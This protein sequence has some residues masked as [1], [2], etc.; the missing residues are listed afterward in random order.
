MTTH[1]ENV[2]ITVITTPTHNRPVHPLRAHRGVSTALLC[3]F[4]ATACAAPTDSSADPAPQTEP[5]EESERGH[6]QEAGLEVSEAWMPEPANPEVGALYL[7]VNNDTDEDDALVG[8]TTDASEEAELHTTETTESGAERMREVAE[9][10]I[11]A[12]ESTAL[13]HGGHHIMVNDLSEP[14]TVGDEVLVT[15]VFAGGTE[16]EFT[17]PVEEMTGGHDHDDHDDHD[18]H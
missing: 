8:V 3:A 5:N 10:P 2:R 13:V 1:T 16:L 11:P 7:E 4:L 15:L 14:L 6:G 12:G 17:A 9:I 18:D